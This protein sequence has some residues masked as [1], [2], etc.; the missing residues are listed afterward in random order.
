[1]RSFVALLFVFFVAQPAFAATPAPAAA[2]GSTQ[3]R[4][5]IS[6]W[7]LECDPGQS[8]LTCRVLNQI[9]Q[10]PSGALLIGFAF[11]STADGKTVLTMQVPLGASVASP[12]GVSI[13]GGPSQN[14]SYVTCS[15]QGCFAAGTVNAD[16]LAAMR[17]DKGNVLVTYTILDNNL[18]GHGVT[19]SL[20]LSG[21]SQVYDR[22]K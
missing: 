22:L 18:V 8:S 7:H 5:A 3:A 6:G 10:T 11:T 17:T 19:A 21:F 15:Q 4:V 1:M 2:S 9:V 14:F 12:I 16:L 20:S 13:A